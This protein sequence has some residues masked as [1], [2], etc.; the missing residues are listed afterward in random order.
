[1]DFRAKLHQIIFEAD[2]KPGKLF[3]I[4]LLWCIVLSVFAVVIETVQGLSTNIIFILRIFEWV[5]T[6]LFTIEYFLR[7]YCVNKSSKYIFSFFGVIDLIAI[8]PTYIGLFFTGTHYISVIRAVRLLRVFRVLKLARYLVGANEILSALKASRG[9]IVVF[10]GFLLVCVLCMGSILYVV[11]GPENGFTSIPMSMYWAVVTMTTVGFG[12]I[13]P[14]TPVGQTISAFVMILGYGI[15]AVPTGIV[16]AKIKRLDNQIN[17]NSQV[18]QNCH[19][20]HHQDDAMYCRI[21][22]NKIKVD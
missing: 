5:F 20:T 6:I 3:D 1:M 15:I 2:T 21:C 11:E 19:A 22:A 16:S 8:L 4:I 12:D 13:T 14:K 9:K 17:T 10:L 7:I 18:C